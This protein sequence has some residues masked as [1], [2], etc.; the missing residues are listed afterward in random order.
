MARTI[1][2]PDGESWTVLGES[3][4]EPSLV[5]IV[6]KYLGDDCVELLDEVIDYAIAAQCAKCE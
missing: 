1:Y 5:R 3:D 4:A 2:L 6:Q